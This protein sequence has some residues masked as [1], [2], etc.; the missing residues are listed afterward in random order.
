MRYADFPHREDVAMLPALALAVALTTDPAV[1]SAWPVSAKDAELADAE[2]IWRD[3]CDDLHKC[4][5][6]FEDQ[7]VQFERALVKNGRGTPDERKQ[8]M[9]LSRRHEECRTELHAALQQLEG[10]HRLRKEE[11]D[12]R[13]EVRAK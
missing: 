5:E 1:A 13:A 11:R 3:R 12:L 2:V 4:A 7:V 9:L 6:C 8:L 10:V